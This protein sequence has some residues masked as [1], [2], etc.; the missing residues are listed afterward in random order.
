MSF[1]WKKKT[2]GCIIRVMN[3]TRNA[4]GKLSPGLTRLVL[5]PRG[6]FSYLFWCAIRNECYGFLRFVRF[7]ILFEHQSIFDVNVPIFNIPIL[8]TIPLSTKMD[9]DEQTRTPCKKAQYER[10]VNFKSFSWVKR[11]YRLQNYSVFFL[12]HGYK[13]EP[14]VNFHRDRMQIKLAIF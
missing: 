14:R 5:I 8:I 4:L 13:T 2:V 7:S 10:W 6:F 9:L 12:H 11:H 3:E 1:C